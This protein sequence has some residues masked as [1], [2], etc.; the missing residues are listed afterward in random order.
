[1]LQYILQFNYLVF[2]SGLHITYLVYFITYTK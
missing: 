1:M 2:T